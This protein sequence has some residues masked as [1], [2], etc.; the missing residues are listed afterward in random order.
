MLDNTRGYQLRFKLSF[1]LP[2][3]WLTWLGMFL[4]W[5]TS[6][7]PWQV[8]DLL[9]R[10]VGKKMAHKSSYRQH[11]AT[12][13]LQMAFPEKS[14]AERQA[15]LVSYF[16]TMVR[17]MLDYGILWWGSKRKLNKLI[18][19][20]GW[21]YLQQAR[22]KGQNVIILTGHNVALD[23]GATAFR[24]QVPVVGLI[25][26]ARSEVVD[27]LM[28]RGRLRFHTVLYERHEGLR[29]VVREIKQGTVFYYL[30]DE[31]LSHVKGSDWVFA[32]FFNVPTVTI[33]SLGKLAKISSATVIP[34]MTYYTGK[35]KYL[36]KIHPPLADFPSGDRQQDAERQS[37]VLQQM[38]E[39]YP[40]QYMW[41]LT[42]F[43]K[44]PNDAPSPY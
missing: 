3:Y 11:I 9:A 1:F 43:R 5:V 40:E 12:V 10:W 33:T 32:P 25:K 41:T 8:R 39:E 38:V 42:L 27:W 14:D 18:Q 23:A 28:G 16:S 34:A 21:E 44:R 20:E 36:V 30:P 26:R 4:L 15:M 35:G 13:N 19:L 2:K 7:L 31:D 6:L 17:S 37:A 24:M 29:P 22:D